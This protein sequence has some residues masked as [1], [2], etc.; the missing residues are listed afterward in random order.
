MQVFGGVLEQSITSVVILH[1]EEGN[2]LE[3]PPSKGDDHRVS[4]LQDPLMPSM[5]FQSHLYGTKQNGQI[6]IYICLHGIAIT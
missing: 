3:A 6:I 4:S 2:A 1:G 5:L